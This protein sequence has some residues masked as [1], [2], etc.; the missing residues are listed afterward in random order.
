MLT[1]LKNNSS[2]TGM[3]RIVLPVTGW[4]VWCRER[5]DPWFSKG[6]PPP[7]QKKAGWGTLSCK[8]LLTNKLTGWATRPLARKIP[9]RP[10]V[11]VGH[12]KTPT[13][14]KEG[15]MGHPLGDFFQV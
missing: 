1:W 10:G 3:P 4:V 8:F 9:T 15:G 2:S 7:R 12:T 13:P 5:K 6:T 11:V 14:P